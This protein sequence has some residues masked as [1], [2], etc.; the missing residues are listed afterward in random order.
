LQFIASK[1]GLWHD[2]LMQD[3]YQIIRIHSYDEIIRVIGDYALTDPKPLLCLTT[4]SLQALGVGGAWGYLALLKDLHPSWAPF[5]AVDC[6]DCAGYVLSCLRHGIKHVFYSGLF[7]S[8]L[9]AAAKPYDA[10]VLPL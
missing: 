1:K 4:Q 6:G 10:K 3:V 8:R 2:F 5:F 7:L 9:Q